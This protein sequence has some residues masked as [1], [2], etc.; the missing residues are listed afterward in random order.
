MPNENEGEVVTTAATQTLSNKTF[1]GATAFATNG[2]R[3]GITSDATPL[4]PT[5]LIQVVNSQVTVALRVSSTWEGTTEAPFQNNDNSLWETFNRTVSD[6]SNLSWSISAPNG[7]ND[8]PAGVYD[9][10]ERVGVYG[11][12][13]SVNIPTQFVH[14]GRLSSQ[15]G[16]R[17]RAGFQGSETPSPLGAR[18]DQA[19]GVLGEIRGDSPDAD[20]DV[21]RAGQFVS[22]SAA[23]KVR[24]NV[25]VYAEAAFGTEDNWSF[26]GQS[27]NFFNN[28]KAFFGA[29]STSA[30]QSNCALSARGSVPNAIEF[31]AASPSGFGSNIGA[32]PASGWPF[33][34]F[35]CEVDPTGDTFST[36]GRKGT[37]LYNDLSGSLIFARVTE[38]SSAGQS[39]AE[40]GRFDE[41]GRFN[42]LGDM[43]VAG[44]AT[45][46]IVRQSDA[47]VSI[48]HSGNSVEFGSSNEAGYGSTIGATVGSGSPFLTF[49]G[50]AD[51]S[52]DTF[53]TRG[54]KGTVIYGDLSG[55]LVFARLPNADAA[56]QV[57]S[58]SG[59]FDES[60]NFR[61]LAGFSVLGTAVFGTVRQSNSKIAARQAGNSVEFGH[62]NP[63]GYAS[64]L[65]ATS[66]SG[67]PFLALNAE[68]D[69][70]GN[71]FTTRGRR[72]VVISSDLNGSLVFSRLTDA[73]A[74]GQSLSQSARFDPEGRLVLS[75]LPTYDN[76][77]AAL[78]ASLVVGTVYKTASGELRVIV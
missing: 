42:L 38:A 24:N 34:G 6:S 30:S 28:G 9:S 18:V 70:A 16:V 73:N 50:E 33:V 13:V 10:G 23:T 77:A 62:P 15:I 74:E 60:G 12:A 3:I 20:I 5:G 32:T 40:S 17:G 66:P 46:G 2:S 39:L 44:L 37:V 35:C 59:K 8:I 27:G 41:T 45:I 56:Q 53:R 76:N 58:E 7:Y 63:A 51:P 64:N 55:G 11:W 69:A 75:S 19:V 21:A 57:P 43:N 25:A 61:L 78:A 4:V 65:G 36:R 31:G 52:G 26:Y 71:T 1:L 29:G 67:L 47:R 72:G 68:A 48:R 14:A 54:R 22:T 49:C